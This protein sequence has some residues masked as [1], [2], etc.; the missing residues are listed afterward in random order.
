VLS[1]KVSGYHRELCGMFPDNIL[2]RVN[3]RKVSVFDSI[4][5]DYAENVSIINSCSG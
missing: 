4:G 5:V 3:I 2:Y 1:V